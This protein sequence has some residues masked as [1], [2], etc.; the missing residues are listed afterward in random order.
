[1]VPETRIFWVAN[2][3]DLVILACTVFD[4][5]T[6][7]TDTWTDGQTELQWLRRAESRSC[8]RA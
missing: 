7:V 4:R 5:S 6:P 2:D 1:M 3:K 8:F